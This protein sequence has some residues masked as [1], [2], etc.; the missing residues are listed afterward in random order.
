MSTDKCGKTD[1]QKYHVK[2]SG[3]DIKIQKSMY[4]DETN[5]QYEMYDYTGKQTHYKRNL[6]LEHN[7]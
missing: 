3:K 4:R 7:T 5:V 1:G 6:Y 2:G